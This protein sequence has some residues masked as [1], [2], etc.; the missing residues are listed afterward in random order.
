MMKIKISKQNA[1]DLS[2]KELLNYYTNLE[3][4]HIPIVQEFEWAQPDWSILGFENDE[5][6]SFF[7]IV[8]R[9]VYFNN[10]PIQVAGINNVITPVQYR[11]HGYSTHLLRSTEDFIFKELNCQAGLLLCADV[12]IPF[13]EKF[14]WYTVHCPVHFAQSDGDKIWKANTMI[15]TK[16]KRLLP[17]TIHLNGLPW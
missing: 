12:L 10:V 7:N 11:G 8:E 15:K 5:L 9:E 4:G 13:Y 2:T 14:N 17:E 1:L 6:V 3:F 16:D